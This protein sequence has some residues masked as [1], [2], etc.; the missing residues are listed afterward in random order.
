M[1]D[2]DA[3]TPTADELIGKGIDALVSARPTTLVH[4]NNGRGVYA[5][6]FA[7]WRAQAQLMCRRNADF[8]KNG[9]IRFAKGQPLRFLAGSEFDTP[10]TLTATTAVG[11]VTLT[12]AAGR[13]GG[14]IR[15]GSR[16][17]RPADTSDLQLWPAAQYVA[18]K[19]TFVLQGATSITIPIDATRTGPGANRP[20]TGTLATEIEIADDIVDRLAWTV[21]SYEMAGG[22]DDISDEDLQDYA[23]AFSSGQHGP[24]VNAAIAGALK[25]GAK[26]A[27]AVDDP[28]TA[29]LLV[30]AADAS[31][32]SSTR[33]AATI[34][35]GLYDGKFVGF[36][37][38]VD[39]LGATNVVVGADIT[40]R[41]RSPYFLAETTPLEGSIRKALRAYFDERPDWNLWKSSALRGTVARADRR[42]LTCSA[43]DLKKYD[44]TLVSEPASASTSHYM[45]ADNAV[46][47]TFL[48]P[49]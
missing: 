21:A 30:Y 33:W 9:R 45:L 20:L 1:S 13:P 25:S 8:A 6:V 38:R 35:Q 18:A 4:V 23:I 12:R 39:V 17:F 32:A 43:V 26:H 29:S 3:Q 42:L 34:R 31:W 24:N 47:V 44:G 19:D 46:R 15:K 41:V 27:I 48:P 22:A 36:G 5:N 11:Q 40:V 7:G 2:P 14:T 10:A 49:R 28:A 16:F 37:C